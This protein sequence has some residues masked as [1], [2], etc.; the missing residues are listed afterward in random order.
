MGMPLNRQRGRVRAPRGGGRA[1]RL[2]AV[3]RD[4]ADWCYRQQLGA[5]LL[6]H[7]GC[8]DHVPR[9]AQN[10]RDGVRAVALTGLSAE[11]LIVVFLRIR[12][13]SRAFDLVGFAWR[14]RISASSD[15]MFAIIVCILMKLT[16]AHE[17]LGDVGRL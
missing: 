17:P 13:R 16:A 7:R 12:C 11:L 5:V 6:S 10:P 4:L 14:G 2:R 15:A 3:H 8:Y 9:R 1:R